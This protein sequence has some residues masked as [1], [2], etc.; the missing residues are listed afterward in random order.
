MRGAASE[1][2]FGP[3][4]PFPS[5]PSALLTGPGWHVRSAPSSLL[6]GCVFSSALPVET[7][8]GSQGHSLAVIPG[9]ISVLLGQFQKFYSHYVTVYVM[10]G[11]RP[12][13]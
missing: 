13:A 5:F 4:P 12:R 2:G 7:K 1:D 6:G 8:S 11:I 3:L 9:V 10:L